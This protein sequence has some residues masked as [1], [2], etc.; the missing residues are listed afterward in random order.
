MFLICTYIVS[1]DIDFC[2]LLDCLI[3]WK[4]GFN[5]F[6]SKSIQSEYE[7]LK[8]HLLSF[9]HSFDMVVMLCFGFNL[10]TFKYQFHHSHHSYQ[11]ESI[12]SVSGSFAGCP[13]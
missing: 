8:T 3:Q 10:E 9:I 4:P 7:F 12:R 6:Q 1:I 2:R 11:F 5:R 13:R